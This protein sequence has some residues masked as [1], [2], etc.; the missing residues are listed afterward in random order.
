MLREILHSITEK[1]SRSKRDRV[2]FI[3]NEGSLTYNL[4]RGYEYFC[5]RRS[6][7]RPEMSANSDGVVQFHTWEAAIVW[8]ES[9][10]RQFKLPVFSIKK[11]YLPQFAS[12]S[13]LPMPGSPYLFAI[14][15]DATALSSESNNT[16]QAWNHTCTGTNPMLVVFDA[17]ENAATDP[18]TDMT[19]NSVP[20]TVVNGIASS[21]GNRYGK[22]WSQGNPTT[23]SS[24]SIQPTLSP[25]QFN[26]GASISYSGCAT[27]A[28]GNNTAGG[29]SSTS[30]NISV[31]PNTAGN[32]DWAVWGIHNTGGNTTAVNGTKRQSGGAPMAMGDSNATVSSA[33]YT[34][35]LTFTNSNYAAVIVAITPFVTPSGPANVKTWDGVT[36]STGVKTYMGVTLANTKTWDGIS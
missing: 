9:K 15:F 16:G 24:L 14:A 31:T 25:S 32:N 26:Q 12:V 2:D 8:T 33:G 11:V 4:F 36:Q 22:M 28:D 10:I 18:Y 13:G 30:L 35:Q 20:M 5:G 34:Q 29:S 17:A 27:T 21:T 1:V 7:I 6:G 23:G 3:W 19:Y